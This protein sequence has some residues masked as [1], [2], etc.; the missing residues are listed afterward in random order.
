MGCNDSNGSNNS[1]DRN[2]SNGSNGNNT[3]G[4]GREPW[5][6][7]DARSNAP[8]NLKGKNEK[9]KFSV[10]NEDFKC[11]FR[12]SKV[13]K[14]SSS[15]VLSLL[16]SFKCVFSRFLSLLLTEKVSADA[17]KVNK[18]EKIEVESIKAFLKACVSSWLMCLACLSCRPSCLSCL[19]LSCKSC[20][21]CRS[22]CMW[23]RWLCI[24]RCGL[25]RWRSSKHR[26]SCCWL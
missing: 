19:S 8:A 25:R 13:F 9:L 16:R 24:C 11:D 23:R 14:S 15:V 7:L 20:K 6:K 4:V 3:W 5:N 26:S 22:W 10:F 2:N 12:V 21:S 1:N 17:E 18:V